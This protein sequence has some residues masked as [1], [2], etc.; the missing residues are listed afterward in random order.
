M[1]LVFNMLRLVY[2]FQINN[3]FP[4]WGI[5]VQDF[6]KI[7]NGRREKADGGLRIIFG[8]EKGDKQLGSVSIYQRP[9]YPFKHDQGT[10][11][12][13]RK[14]SLTF[15]AVGI[16]AWERPRGS[17]QLTTVLGPEGQ[18]QKGGWRRFGK[19]FNEDN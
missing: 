18:S 10:S 4:K 14:S 6:F 7:G 19:R 16:S 9:H 11:K 13:K 12:A 1:S 8:A 15:I 3:A 17:G 5:D 2:L